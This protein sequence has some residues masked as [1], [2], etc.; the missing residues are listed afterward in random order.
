M[1]GHATRAAQLSDAMSAGVGSVAATTGTSTSGTTTGTAASSAGGGSVLVEVAIAHATS[2][3]HTAA[4]TPTV[5]ATP[6]ATTT[7]TAEPS[8]APAH[9]DAAATPAATP[10]AASS[11]SA[12][13]GSSS[14]TGSARSLSCDLS[15]G[16][17]PANVSAIVSFLLASGYSDNAAA[18]I[19][20]NIYQ[21]SKGNPESEGMGGGGLIGWTP[22]P[23]G[24]VT[25]DVS[26]DLETQLNALLTYNKGWSQYL[27]AL[28]EA[29]S[30]ASAAYIYVTEFERAGIP[31]ATTREAAAA[32]VAAACGI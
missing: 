32:D 31:A 16:L 7:P 5:A 8:A 23:S 4:A 1:G 19:A 17:L 29:A 2:L 3:L 21:E 12:S 30:P 13:T 28:N 9:A 18:G 10:S 15:G 24:Y 6:T 22:L 27:P 26:A 11:A 25:G 20:G 14:A